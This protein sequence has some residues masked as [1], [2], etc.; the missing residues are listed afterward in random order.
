MPTS[1]IYCP[2]KPVRHLTCSMFL[3]PLRLIFIDLSP[4]FAHVFITNR[5]LITFTI[6]SVFQIYVTSRLK[7]TIFF[8]NFCTPPKNRTP[9]NSLAGSHANVTPKVCLPRTGDSNP[10]LHSDSVICNHYTTPS[11]CGI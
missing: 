8:K 11:F 7:V 6:S 10:N 4:V 9:T 3:K 1:S 2:D 5:S